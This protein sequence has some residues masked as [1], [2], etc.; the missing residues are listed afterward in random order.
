MSG[1]KDPFAKPPEWFIETPVLGE[2]QR[3]SEQVRK[4]F[5]GQAEQ[6]HRNAMESF[7]QLLQRSGHGVKRQPEEQADTE[8]P[9]PAKPA[10]A[11]RD[12]AREAIILA[13]DILRNELGRD[14]H[15]SEVYT[16]L[17]DGRD[18]DENII[19]SDPHMGLKWY[20]R[21]ANLKLMTQKQFNARYKMLTKDD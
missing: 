3:Q 16:F 13:I 5:E 19:K 1:K 8:Q 2:L 20:D 9:P 18:P 7:W 12:P 17:A 6:A 14:P 4:L 15:R 11:R 10:I 21:H